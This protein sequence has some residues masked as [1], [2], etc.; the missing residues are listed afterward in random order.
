MRNLRRV[1]SA[2]GNINVSSYYCLPNATLW[3]RWQ[4]RASRRHCS[5]PCSINQPRRFFTSIQRDRSSIDT[6]YALSTA[7]GRAAIAIIRV[8]GPQCLSIYRRLCPDRPL[9]KPR[10]AALRRLHDPDDPTQILD[11]G[12]L[13]L[14]FPAPSSVT[15]EDVLEFHVHGG[16]AIVKSVLDATPRSTQ[17]KDVV[18]RPA[19]AGEFTKRAFYNGLLDLTQAEALGESLAAET[20]QQRRL[21]VSGASNVLAER[22]EQWRKMLLHARGELEALIDFSEDQHFDESPDEL[23]ENVS[24]QVRQLRRQIELHIHNANKGELLRNGISVALLGPPNAGK[25]SLLNMIVG[26]EAAIVNTEAGTTRDIVD[27]SIDL[28][29]WLVRL[30]DMAGL[31]GIQSAQYPPS[32]ARSSIGDVEQEGIRRARERALQS[33]LVLVIVSLQVSSD[34]RA[35]LV[36]NDELIS[37]VNECRQVGKSLL[38]VLNKIDLLHTQTRRA[39]ASLS[40]L[41]SEVMEVFPGISPNDCFCISCKDVIQSG[42]MELDPGGLQTFLGGLTKKFASMTTALIGDVNFGVPTASAVSPEGAK[43]YWTTSLSVTHRQSL[44]LQNCLSKLEDFLKLA[45]PSNP[46]SR[47][48][49][50]SFQESRKLLH[51]SSGSDS[52]ITS[53]HHTDNHDDLVAER[54]TAE[55]ER[56]YEWSTTQRAEFQSGSELNPDVDIVTAAESLRYAA[57]DLAMVTGKGDPATGGLSDVQDVLG[58]VFEK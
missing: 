52:I 21:A 35:Q 43:R 15:G 31:R 56:D 37:A 29:G 12:S 32:D 6:I 5:R 47:N 46:D 19:E 57:N 38:F 33:D 24:N 30:G 17:N 14:Y 58:V 42:S 28:S 40:S 10:V 44:Y 7:P 4:S 48:L 13:V 23:M 22:Y 49:S 9:P 36:L 16:P 1:V 54:A 45:Q 3:Q 50:K 20:E 2:S 34:G 41:L 18:I 26:R 11:T 25:S 27:V 51:K 39:Q 53:S 8:S 55:L